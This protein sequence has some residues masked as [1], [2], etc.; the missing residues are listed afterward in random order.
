MPPKLNWESIKGW[1]VVAIISVSVSLFATAAVGKIK[2]VDNAA[3]ENYVDTKVVKVTDYV[4][5]EN[6]KQDIDILTNEA[7]I[8]LLKDETHTN[9]VTITEVKTRQEYSIKMIERLL[10]NMDIPRTD[11]KKK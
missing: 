6:A 1:I 9:R 11:L 10:D 8:L 4:D 3:S 2:T 7:Q 5:R